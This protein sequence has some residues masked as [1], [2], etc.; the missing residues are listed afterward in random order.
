M[1]AVHTH[2]KMPQTG[3]HLEA[4]E[5]RQLMAVSWGYWPTRL[6]M[7]QVFQNYPWLTG[8]GLNVAVIDKG[9][10][11]LHP[12]LGGNPSTSTKSTRIVNV[13]D[14]RDND[15]D[16]FPSESQLT[17]PST[18]HGTGVASILVGLP[19]TSVNGRHYQGILQD[20]KLFNLRTN[21]FDS[22]NTIK[23]ALKWVLD[24][25]ETYNITA[26][27]LTDFIGTGSSI[28][29]YQAEI[30]A[31]WN[32]NIF[33]ATPVANDWQGDPQT[34]A[35]AKAPIGLPGS[36]PYIFGTGG[37]L[38]NGAMNP[39][40]QRGPGLDILGPSEKVALAYY[41]PTTNQHVWLENSDGSGQG[42]GNS[43]GTP[44]VIGTAVLIQQID[45]TITPTEIMAILKDSGVPVVDPDGTGNYASLDMI[46][47]I[48]LAYY[49]RD[50]NI[51]KQA[52]G[53]DSLGNAAAIA[54]DNNN[55]GSVGSQ[56]LLVG[57]HDY[58]KFTVGT[59]SDFNINIG[60]NGGTAFPTVQL[61][62]SNGDLIQTIGSGGIEQK[63][64]AAGT[65]YVHLTGP[66]TLVGTYSV[67]INKD[68]VPPPPPGSPGDNGSF[69]DIAFDSSNNL[70]FAWFDES[71]QTL[72]FAKRNASKVWSSVQ[73]VDGNQGAGFYVSMALDSTGKPGLAYYDA[74]NGDLKYAKY[75]GA[76]WSVQTI[77]SQFTT[78]YY[79]S[80]KF[81]AGNNPV[82]AYYYKT[83]KDLRMA[84]FSGGNWN[85]S[86]VDA[87]ND[88]GRFP[89]LAMNPAAGR[90]AI[91]YEST[92]TGIFR[93]A[94]QT[95]SGWNYTDVDDTQTGG[96]NISL[97]FD[98]NNLPA[99]SYYDAANANLKFARFGNNKWNVSTLASKGSQG[100]YTNLFFDPGND[101]L[102]VIYYYNKT[103]DALT[104]ARSNSSTWEF[105]VLAAGG[106]RNN[107]V[108]LNTSDF[109]TFSWLDTASGS[110]KVAD[111]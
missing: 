29:V 96:G 37:I 70:N 111:S 107:H 63:R 75:D 24:N 60:Y 97:A 106:G 18:A 23:K 12:Q 25:H 45:P 64:L 44:H 77:D 9:I 46:E 28:P 71:S 31:L 93:Y 32:A 81:G 95:K 17:D 40:T 27:N 39:K 68:E 103:N 20:S 30:Q 72:K 94:Q 22:Q 67:N 98:Q 85:I 108:S 43:W 13:Y 79:P 15:N 33:I 26:I 87:R 86:T 5:G 90:W 104:V 41:T 14:Y 80:L 7:D 38:A 3:R 21:R 4:L 57:D 11:Y 69:N 65:Y 61:L 101:F 83:G 10:D 8:D 74:G 2:K 89:S 47:A 88:I 100:L 54:L 62:D 58:F 19:Y 49:R 16:P 55:S 76:N 36:S 48:E 102:P 35:G 105:E 82:I 53:N 51:D 1:K 73:I 66:K 52:G 84:A 50:D 56:K 34:G 110:V 91:A 42:Q 99:F 59:P 109:E 78:G 6:H 92:S